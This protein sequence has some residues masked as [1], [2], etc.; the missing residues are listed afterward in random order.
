[1]AYA[2]IADLQ[3]RLPGI[4][5]GAGTKPTSTQVSTWITDAEGMLNAALSGAQ[6][7]QPVTNANGILVCKGLV[8]D[9]AEGRTRLA[10]DSTIS[11]DANS[12]GATLVRDFKALLLELTKPEGNAVWAAILGGGGAGGSTRT[13]R[14]HVTDNPDGDSIADGDFDPEFTKD[15]AW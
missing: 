1:M 3:A 2:V 15:E 8:L 7:T 4:T 5:F 11:D 12:L 9:Y 13:V 14:S 6:I 10:L